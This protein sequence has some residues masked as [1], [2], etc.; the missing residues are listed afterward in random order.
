[1]G[2]EEVAAQNEGARVLCKPKPD[3]GLGRQGLVALLLHVD[4]A[5]PSI[6]EGA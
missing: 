6:L 3:Q 4:P 5:D 1:M 2:S